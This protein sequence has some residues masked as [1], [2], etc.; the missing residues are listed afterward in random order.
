MHYNHSMGAQWTSFSLQAK[1][2]LGAHNIASYLSLLFGWLAGWLA[3]LREKEK[4]SL[5]ASGVCA[6]TAIVCQL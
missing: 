6:M 1:L 4:R 2:S 3:N 5:K